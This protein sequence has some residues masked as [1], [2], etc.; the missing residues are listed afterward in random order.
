MVYLVMS[1]EYSAT[2]IHGYFQNAEDAYDYCEAKNSQSKNVGG[3]YRTEY[4]VE[5]VREIA[6][7]FPPRP[8]RYYSFMFRAVQNVD[9][10]KWIL[11]DKSREP[12]QI[13]DVSD[14]KTPPQRVSYYKPKGFIGFPDPKEYRIVVTLPVW[15]YE[16]ADKIAQ[17]YFYQVVA[18]T[19]GLST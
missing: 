1:G 8:P 7:D 14:V 6:V 12:F 16:L 11:L 18:N 10:E 5:P 2:E 19:E 15:D 4:Y 9:S 3:I 17:D 13:Q